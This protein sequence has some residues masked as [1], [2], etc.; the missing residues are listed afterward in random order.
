[1]ILFKNCNLLQK[2]LSF[3]DKTDYSKLIMRRAISETSKSNVQMYKEK[4][5]ISENKKAPEWI[6]A[7]VQ[8]MEYSIN[9]CKISH[10]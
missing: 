7:E 6:T 10:G 9:I 1:M 4:E 3:K 2:N 5:K 8:C